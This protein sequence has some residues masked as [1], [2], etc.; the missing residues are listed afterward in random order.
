LRSLLFANEIDHEIIESQARG[1]IEKLACQVVG[2]GADR[3]IVAGGDGSIHEAVNGILQANRHA[4]LGIIPMGTGNDFAKAC[5]MPPHWEDAAILLADRIRSGAPNLVIDVGQMN[6]RFFANS[7]G[8]GFDAKVTGIAEQ[9]KLPIGDIVYLV[10]VFRAM[11]DGV[12]TPE[13]RVDYDNESYAG[14]LTLV[15]I[16]NGDWVG[17]MFQI[18]PMAKNDDGVLE[19][20]IAKPISN[21]RLLTLLPRLLQGSH[22]GLPEIIH[23]PVKRC[24]IVATGPIPSHLDGEMQP[25]YSEFSIQIIEGGLHLL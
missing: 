12:T 2:N 21:W 22:I 13:L 4:A 8:I 1:D 9:I 24:E 6:D 5:A 10:A 19:L 20:I 23:A 14:P 17:G 16:S 7:A 25:M 11:W 3:V 18:A 15:S